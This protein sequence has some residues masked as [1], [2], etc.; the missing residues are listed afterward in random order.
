MVADS[1][2]LNDAPVLISFITDAEL[3][4]LQVYFKGRAFNLT[5]AYISEGP[6]CKPTYRKQV[7]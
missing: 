2:E 6:V 4:K 1:E 3:K 5:V 7:N